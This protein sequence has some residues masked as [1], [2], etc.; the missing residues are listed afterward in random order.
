M[1]AKALEVLDRHTFVPVL[2]VDMNP[3]PPLPD[4][5]MSESALKASLDAHI[6]RT[7]LLRR[8]GYPCTGKPNVIITRLNGSGKATNDPY[9]WGD[10]TFKVAHNYII[11][12]WNELK[13]GDVIDV[14]FILGETAAP[15]RSER[16]AALE[17]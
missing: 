3:G 14:E 16:V 17:V 11:E 13:D 10:R 7:Y 2:A 6:G 4:G 15:K 8:C 12:H 5:G 1:K 9:E